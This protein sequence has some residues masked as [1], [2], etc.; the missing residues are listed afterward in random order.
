MRRSSAVKLTLLPVL[1]TAAVAHIATAE[2]PTAAPSEP[3][4]AEPS[5]P[6]TAEPSDPQTTVVTEPMYPALS[7][8]S[9]TPTIL[10][11][12]CEEDP[13]WQLRPDCWDDG[14]YYDGGVIRGGF[15]SYFY[16]GSVG[17]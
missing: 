5:D 16:G 2:P 17:G 3:P 7:P 1:A 6:P 9:M 8:P 4:T 11:L 10:E 15:G 14:Y 13:N 12:R